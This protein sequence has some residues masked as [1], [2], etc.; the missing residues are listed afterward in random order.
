VLADAKQAGDE[1]FELANKLLGFASVIADKRRA[2]AGKWAR[3]NWGVT[4][5]VLDDGFQHWQ[6]RRDVDIVTIDATNPFGNEKLLPAGILREPPLA[7]KRADCI[8]ITRANL[9]ENIANLK[10]QISEINANC[11]IL[12]SQTKIVG[13]RDVTGFPAKAQSLPSEIQR[14][15]ASAFCALGNPDNFF[16]SLRREGFNICTTRTFADHYSYTQKDVD[17]IEKSAR[18]AG[19]DV[20]LTTAK[21]AAKLTGLRFSLPCFVVEIEVVFDD[22]AP[23]R[24]LL[25]AL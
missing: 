14:A 23:L 2:E 25:A 18:K 1:P 12:L 17:E 15:N 5:F 8:V 6:V 22:D 16:E 24:K 19:A 20:L 11:P 10:S 13:L 9:S 21:D 4:A 7:L 3:E